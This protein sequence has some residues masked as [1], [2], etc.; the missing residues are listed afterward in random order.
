MAITVIFATH[1]GGDRL[2][3]TLESMTVLEKPEGDWQLIVVDNGST[4]ASAE[5]LREFISRLPLTILENPVPGKNLSLNI[6]LEKAGGELIVFTDDD[7]LV[8][9]KWLVNYHNLAK[10]HPDHS[11]FGCRITANWP[12][13][14]S[15]AVLGGVSLG[16]A[17]AIHDEDIPNGEVEPGKIWG[18]NM[19]VRASVFRAEHRFDENIGPAGRN[20]VPGSES[21][22]NLKLAKAGYR[23]WFDKKNSVGHQ[24]RDEQLT[25]KWLMGRAFRLGRGQVH[26]ALIDGQALPAKTGPYP[27]WYFSFLGQNCLLWLWAA[28]SFNAVLKMKSRWNI[29]VARGMF[30]EQRRLRALSLKN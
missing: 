19:A 20:Y 8:P 11:V 21:A 22:F 30:F 28:I 13:P 17:F 18:P 3:K 15:R 26:W 7:V 6:A 29:Q 9:T 10:N 4:D 23:F 27:R 1:N 16:N 24:I 14:P 12:S 25:K 5:T 2:K